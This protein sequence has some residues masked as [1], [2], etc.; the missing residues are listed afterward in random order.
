MR[1]R[2][3]LTESD[4]SVKSFAK[5]VKVERA[6]VYRYFTGAIPRTRTMRRIELVTNGA[7]TAQDF[8]DTAVQSGSGDVLVRDSG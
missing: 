8:Y 2:D 7:V 3:W 6:M 1:L 4:F 5:E